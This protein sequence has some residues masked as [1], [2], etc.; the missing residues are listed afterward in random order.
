MIVS[1]VLL[2]WYYSIFVGIFLVILILK[3][4][5][6]S[7]LVSIFSKEKQEVELDNTNKIQEEDQASEMA[8][9]GGLSQRATTKS[10]RLESNPDY[11]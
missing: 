7:L 1:R 5:L 4:S 10:Y 8:S 11:I 9:I 6:I 2:T 3:G